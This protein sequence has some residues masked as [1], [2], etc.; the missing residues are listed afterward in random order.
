[1]NPMYLARLA[2][3]LIA[4]VVLGFAQPPQP[5]DP[6][7]SA[8]PA[9][10]AAGKRLFENQCALCHGV[11]GS[12]GRGPALTAPKLRRASDS[13][14]LLDLIAGG[15]ERNGMPA[16]WFL[17]EK[18]IMQVAAYVRSLAAPASETASRGN[19]EHGAAVYRAQGCAACHIATGEGSAFGPELS[20]VGARRSVAYLRESL[21][22]P[23]ASVPSGF[24]MV[25][26]TLRDGTPVAGVR[27]NEDTFTI[28]I[29][30]VSGRFYSFR[31]QELS[32]VHKEFSKSPMPSYRGKL[33]D[34][35]LDD[36]VAWLASL[37]GKP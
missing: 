27:L 5:A 25:E 23:E 3:G 14:E 19:A 6:L 22:D 36:L 32:N 24:V 16:F 31:K 10:I 2:G 1:M 30:D 4:I 20:D 28:Q 35:D 8:T 26:A 37:K 18:P 13:A 21:L 33:S 7:A 15:V 17:G 9:D 29:R 11:G 34:G 12:G